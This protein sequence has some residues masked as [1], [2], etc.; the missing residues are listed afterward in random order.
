MKF[1]RIF[2]GIFFI[3]LLI[4]L[5]GC[6]GADAERAAATQ[7]P[8]AAPTSLP[9][10]PPPP[11]ATPLPSVGVLFAPESADPALVEALNT[12]L[13]Q[14]IPTAG[15][16]YQMRPTLSVESIQADD[17][18]WV[19]ALPP[20]PD[21]AAWAAA[22][23]ETRFLAVGVN[24]IETA[25]NISVIGADGG[26]FDQQGF[27]AGYI[28]AMLT[29]DWRVGVISVADTE[30][31]QLARRSFL[32]GAKFYCGA[33]SP[34]Y[35]PFLEYP[36]YYQVNAG[37]DAAEWQIAADFLLQRN[38]EMIYLGP[39]AGD[40]NLMRYIAQAGARMIGASLPPE[41]VRASWVASL[42]FSPLEAY[43]NFWPEFAAG[44]NG[45]AVDVSLAFSEI[46]P[47]WLS[48]G[49]LHSVEEMYA[50]IR[51][52]TIELMAENIP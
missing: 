15:L 20:A 19:V 3:I 13:T 32:T 5:A 37:A 46:N 21:L 36:L 41:D 45:Q 17:I 9:T 49:R 12:H 38:V 14:A 4:G 23:P 50:E 1:A 44:V 29:P 26:R 43:Y 31:G 40:E 28:A 6:S 7:P 27:L 33:C 39:G 48:M 22:A 10:E 11:T 30:A 2:V 24:G 47:D 25:S 34:T 51:S 35:P 52:G 42:T 8:E 16:R 18:Q